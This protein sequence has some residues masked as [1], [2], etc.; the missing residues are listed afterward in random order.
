MSSLPPPTVP[1]C[2]FCD[3]VI[4]EQGTGKITLVGTFSGVV[5]PTFPSPPRD[6]HVYVQMTSFAGR[7]R[8]DYRVSAQTFLRSTIYINNPQPS[9]TRLVL[10]SIRNCHPSRRRMDGSND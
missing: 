4:V 2:L 6:L 10:R 5:A 8:F 7:S 3:G 9:S 1:P